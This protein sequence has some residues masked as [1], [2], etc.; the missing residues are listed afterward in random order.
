M[1]FRGVMSGVEEAKQVGCLCLVG[2]WEVLQPVTD[3]PTSTWQ[4]T[5][6]LEVYGG[7]ENLHLRHYELLRHV[8]IRLLHNC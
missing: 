2:D 8:Q 1:K 4:G 3:N 5:I 6:L 7:L